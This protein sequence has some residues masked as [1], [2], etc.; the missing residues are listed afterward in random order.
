[1][2]QADDQPALG[3]PALTARTGVGTQLYT[4]AGVSHEASGV[5]S[6][7]EDSD[8][9]D[10]GYQLG[11]ASGFGSLPD[12]DP[13]CCGKSRPARAPGKQVTS[14]MKTSPGSDQPLRSS[15]PRGSQRAW[16]HGCYRAAG[17]RQVAHRQDK[18]QPGP[19]VARLSV[20][21]LPEIAPHRP[22]ADDAEAAPPGRERVHHPQPPASFGEL[23]A[24]K[25]VPPR[26]G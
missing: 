8:E 11:L 7:S 15:C 9:E 24:T 5:R 22:R 6:S 25:P 17:G 2:F 19:R 20:Q 16:P 13:Q 1:M 12:A 18:V 14:E 23:T 21:R 10:A 26:S 3:T 4:P